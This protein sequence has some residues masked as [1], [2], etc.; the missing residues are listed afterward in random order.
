MSDVGMTTVIAD[1]GKGLTAKKK[2]VLERSLSI[3]SVK[4]AKGRII[5]NPNTIIR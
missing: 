5:E 4:Q 3:G 2:C 1:D